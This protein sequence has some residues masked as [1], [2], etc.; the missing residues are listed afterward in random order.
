MVMM[1]IALTGLYF[2]A[3]LLLASA[4]I[5]LALYY[6][7]WKSDAITFAVWFAGI[8]ISALLAWQITDS[9]SSA[10]IVYGTAFLLVLAGSPFISMFTL[11]GLFL[12]AS[13]LLPSLYGLLWF[14]KWIYAL[15]SATSIGWSIV[16]IAASIV[17]GLL[18]ILNTVAWIWYTLLRYS[19]LYFPFT[20][21][22]EAWKKANR[23]RQDYPWVS[24]HVPCYAEPPDMVIETLRALGNLQ[25][26]HFEVIVVDNNTRD[27]ALWKPVEA[28]CLRLGK[29]FRFYHF[30]T[31][32][33]AKAG[34]CNKA[35]EYTSPQVQ[36]VG[37]IDADYVAQPDFLKKLVGFFDDP[38]TGF[39]QSCQDY[40]EW[41]GSTFQ[42]ACYY[43]YEIPFKLELPGASEWNFT[44]TIGT[45]CLL[46]RDVLDKVGGWAEWCLTEDSEVA[47]RIH[48]EG[49]RGYYLKDTLG[50]GLVPENFE[51]YKQQRFRW[52]AGPVQSFQH[53]WRLYMPFSKRSQLI[54]MEKFGEVMHSLN[55][56][57]NE[58]LNLLTL[59]LLF[60]F[61]G[62]AIAEQRH[63]FVPT[64]FLW[65]IPLSIIR[66]IIINWIRIRLLKGGWRESLLAAIASRSLVY[67]RTKAFY[68]AWITSNL[69]W[70]RTEKFKI[71][72]DF[73]RIFASNKPEI[74]TGVSISLIALAIIPYIS[75]W[76]PNILFFIWLR[77]LN[78]AFTY[79]C[80]PIMAYYSEH[81]LNGKP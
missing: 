69:A 74:I 73:W 40:R 2:S 56:L 22:G 61:I 70:K 80:A 57:F 38:K 46:R 71:S 32:A 77:L 35:L 76:P 65:F 30:D 53:H 28:E 9:L 79:A 20:R 25:Y 13:M 17:F 11:F 6:Y 5:T 34:A 45:M 55:I 31:L 64:V 67:T 47:I 54:P 24:L 44:Y 15:S 68:K 36:L 66:N 10:A 7:R 75:F 59:P 18:I 26:P 50:R 23:E 43:E 4:F 51:N 33:G 12:V 58:G 60:T 16:L 39:V 63:F 41:K 37:I 72:S 19:E 42:T 3:F 8:T 1:N 49:Y 78:T 52:T 48:N 29:A 21:V 27:P 14:S 81:H 62:F